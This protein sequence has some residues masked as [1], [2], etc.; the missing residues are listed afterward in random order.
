VSFASSFFNDMGAEENNSILA[1]AEL[2][3]EA[4]KFIENKS[5]SNV[6]VSSL[7]VFIKETEANTSATLALLQKLLIGVVVLLVIISIVFMVIV[8]TALFKWKDPGVAVASILFY[9]ITIIVIHYYI[10]RS[11]SRLVISFE[12]KIQ[13]SL[14][15]LD[16]AVLD[17]KRGLTNGISL[18]EALAGLSETLSLP[19]RNNEDLKLHTERALV[20]FAENDPQFPLSLVLSET[21]SNLSE[22]FLLTVFDGVYFSIILAVIVVLAI[23]IFSQIFTPSQTILASLLLVVILFIVITLLLSTVII[24]DG[25]ST[26]LLA[27]ELEKLESNQLQMALCSY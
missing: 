17:Y 1:T 13:T 25:G 11:I 3:I 27:S 21:Y 6:L 23:A 12:Q 18:S 26:E 19:N 10:R 15:K 8:W 9:I 4:A 5:K 24:D 7:D 16:Q 2:L 20:S 14:A 22:R